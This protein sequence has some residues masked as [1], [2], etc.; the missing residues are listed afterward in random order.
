MPDPARLQVGD[1]ITV[2]V[3]KAVHGGHCLAHHDGRTAFIRHALPGELVNAVV[4]QASAK[5]LRLDAV[6]VLEASADRVEPPCPWSGPGR[7]GGCDFMHVRRDTQRGWK[8]QILRESLI[9]F[10]NLE[11]RDLDDLDLTVHGLPSAPDGLHW[12][13]RVAYAQQPTGRWGLHAARSHDVIAV[14]RCAIA[15]SE[16]AVPGP[17]RPD[18]V[19][20]VHGRAWRVRP[21]MFWQAHVDLPE[22]LVDT[23]LDF[24]APENGETWWDL[25]AGAGLLAAFVGERVGPLGAVVAVEESMPALKAARRALH[26]LP[27]V[28]LVVDDVARWL[29]ASQRPVD[30]II[31]D[32]PRKGAGAEVVAAVAASGPSRIV[33]VACDPV[34]LARDTALLRAQGYAMSRVR[35]FDAFPMSH[36]F[37]TVA[38]FTPTGPARRA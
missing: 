14:D 3:G 29:R 38:L 6:T 20:Q 8:S 2:R 19:A 1:E 32:P 24:G 26:D 9:R 36:H 16:A 4:T 25:Y 30:G 13:T 33:Y 28:G 17:S 10:A 7:C 34:A 11:A 31:L 35:A 15:V 18:F 21:D 12:R 27:Q 22:T 23:V 5:I 37:E